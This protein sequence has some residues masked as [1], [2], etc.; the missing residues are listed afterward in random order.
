[1][2][3]TPSATLPLDVNPKQYVLE[4]EPNFDDFTFTGSESIELD[5]V[6]STDRIVLNSM[7]IEIQSGAVSANGS[8]QQAREIAFD[9]DAETVTF[10]FDSALPAGPATLAI[11]F[12]GELNDKL[13]G[14]YRS[15]YQDLDGAEKFLASTQFE[16]TDARRA[17]PCWDEPSRKATFDVTLVVPS[18]LATISNTEEVSREERPDSKVAVRFAPTPVMS[19]YLVAFVVGDLAC[20]EDTAEGGTLIRV[21]AT[22]G[23]EEKGR[24]ALE[25]SLDLLAYF[26]EYF[27]MSFPLSKLDH[28]AIPDF[29]AGAMENWGAITYRETALLV[30]PDHS[31]AI[32]REVVAAIISHEMAHMW[33]G[34]L[35]TMAWWDDLWL[36]ES[37]ASWMGDKAVD[38][39][40]PEWE[41]WTQFL[42]HDTTNALSLDGLANSHPIEQ[43]V[44]NPAEIGQ[45][46]DAISY[47]KGASILRMLEQYLSP[48]AF[49]D[50]LRIYLNRHKYNNARTRDL[51]NALGEASGQPV[52]E[53]MDTWTTQTG[54]PVLDVTVDR[55]DDGMEVG[56]TQRRFMYEDV[57]GTSES[58]DDRW[59][60]PVGARTASDADP[61]RTLMETESTTVRLKPASYGT[62]DEWIKV[63]PLHTAFYRVRYPTDELQK[64]VAP[65]R[66]KTLPAADRL[67]VQ[68]D[69]YALVKA[70]HLPATDFLTI[71]EAYVAETD[72]SVC[73]DLAANLNGLDG[74]VATEEFYPRFQAFA[75]SIFKPIGDHIGWDPT[76]NEGHRDALL[77]STALSQL[78]HFEDEDTL[79]EAARRFKRYIDDPAN[80]TPDTRAVVFAMAA[81]RGDRSTYDLM[82]DLEKAETLHEQKIRFL[83][84]LCSYTQPDL[85]QETLERSLGSEVRSQDTIRGVSAVASNRH[86]LDIAWDFVKD[87]WAEFD[88]RYGEGGF[89]LMHLVSLTSMFTTEER[90]E[91]VQRFFTDNPVPGAERAVRQSLERMSLNIGWIDKNRNDLASWLVG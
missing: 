65:I 18:H 21:W 72:A 39:L 11:G 90:R 42:T 51:W 47:S 59:K 87:N 36:N 41:M 58:R 77:R 20:I 83:Y 37:F 75:R 17:F 85:L 52:A 33:F 27:G 2:T 30:D 22:K 74:L 7:E 57:L 16:S 14:F 35:V 44:N 3:E 19:T 10:V 64:L 88:R 70:G 76:P 66:S 78:G 1:M 40:H 28:L 50:G 38:V 55:D 80:V 13:R 45:L 49:R 67:G 32:T 8:D 23:N 89:G 48:D 29:A 91:D 63:N 34:D 68:N 81:K 5:V 6:Q 15:N 73:G 46:F 84:A 82:W 60:V 43:E 86:G 12:T 71:A 62:N 69:T 9:T 25:T 26:N 79:A 54:Y 31:S 24:F 4:L 56:L 53:I 61:V